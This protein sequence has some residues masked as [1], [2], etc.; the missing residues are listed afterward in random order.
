M[1]RLPTVGGLIGAHASLVL[2]WLI[3][4]RET[5]N[6]TYDLTD[7]N[8]RGLAHFIGTAVDAGVS[9]VT[10]YLQEVT[11]DEALRRHIAE[12]TE[13]SPYSTISDAEARYGR[14]IGWYALV[15]LQRP[16]VVVETGVDKGLGTCVIASAL[17]RNTE[18]GSPGK[19]VAIDISPRAGW[20]IAQPYSE[21]VELVIDDSHAA[22]S[23]LD[24]AIDLFIHDSAHTYEHEAGEYQIIKERLS[25]DAV[26]LSDNAHGLPTLMDFAEAT[27][28]RYHF[29]QEKP[30]GHFYSGAGIGLVRF[31]KDGIGDQSR[32]A[33]R[34]ASTL[35]GTEA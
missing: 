11:S 9:Q 23:S 25:D 26:L 3:R 8:Q 35:I 34:L 17:L 33:S 22:L 18:E 7:H 16:A 4:S 32:A 27:G 24:D 29:W 12:R 14:R 10:E 13:R 21:V 31:N 15:R 1:R 30:K 28:Q 2:Q 19:V 5:D 20:L 6:F